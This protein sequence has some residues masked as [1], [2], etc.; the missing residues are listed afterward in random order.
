[1][2]PDAQTIGNIAVYGFVTELLIYF[3][4]WLENLTQFWSL[5]VTCAFSSVTAYLHRSPEL[6]HSNEISCADSNGDLCIIYVN[7][8]CCGESTP[9]TTAHIM[10]NHQCVESMRQNAPS[11]L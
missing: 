2:T 1:M 4:V 11:A 6:R 10:C 7:I 8:E 9:A 3:M 5:T